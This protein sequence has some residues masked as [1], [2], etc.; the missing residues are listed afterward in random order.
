[1]PSLNY[2][3]I[4][5]ISTLQFIIQKHTFHDSKST[6]DRNYDTTRYPAPQQGTLE[7]K[8]LWLLL[9]SLYNEVACYFHYKHS[10]SSGV[11]SAKLLATSQWRKKLVS[12][13]KAAANFKYRHDWKHQIHIIEPSEW[14]AGTTLCRNGEVSH[15][16]AG[17][18]VY[19]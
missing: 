13:A 3:V 6:T 1:M 16:P 17:L 14:G 12:K 19:Y 15:N 7:S 5:V 2:I 8:I 18:S 9:L 4:S 10:R 11:F